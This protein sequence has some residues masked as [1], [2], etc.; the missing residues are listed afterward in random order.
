MYETDVLLHGNGTHH[1]PRFVHF[2]DL[3]LAVADRYQKVIWDKLHRKA[4]RALDFVTANK[5]DCDASGE[6]L[7]MLVGLV[8]EIHETRLSTSCPVLTEAHK[9]LAMVVL[10]Y[11]HFLDY[12]STCLSN[13]EALRTVRIEYAHDTLDIPGIGMQRVYFG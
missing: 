12:L 3:D 8:V 6:T 13:L 9:R 11:H 5:I 10:E 2:Y 4:M 1:I 7:R